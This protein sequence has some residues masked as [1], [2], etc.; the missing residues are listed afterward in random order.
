MSAVSQS[1]HSLHKVQYLSGSEGKA[2]VLQA[3][4][5]Q[6]STVLGPDIIKI[7]LQGEQRAAF[8]V[9]V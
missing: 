7:T 5:H 9:T 1:L 4:D 6:M 8:S 3:T 2:H